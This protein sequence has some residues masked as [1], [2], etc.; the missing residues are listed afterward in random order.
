MKKYQLH[1]NDLSTSLVFYRALF[2]QMPEEIGPDRLRFETPKLQLSITEAR[3]PA[4]P[5]DP[6]SLHVDEK[7]LIEVYDRMRRF[8][9]KQRFREQ[10]EELNGAIGLTD[11]DGNQWIIG[12]EQREV[13]FEKCYIN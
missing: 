4:I 8:T 1:S 13:E 10:C 12:D 11:P 9:A 3:V 6:F 5:T 2:N 7:D